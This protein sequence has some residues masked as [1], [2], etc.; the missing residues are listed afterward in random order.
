MIAREAACHCGRLR[1][2]CTGEPVRV[3][4]CHCHACQRRTGSVFGVQARF[5]SEQVHITGEACEYRRI[6][7]S[8]LPVVQRFCPACGSTVWWT[9]ERDAGLVAVAVGAFA[10]AAFPPPWVAVYEACRHPWTG[11]PALADIEHHA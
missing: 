4:M 2:T 3:S 9:L 11:L 1:V 8:G 7:D 5:R 10:D 6:G